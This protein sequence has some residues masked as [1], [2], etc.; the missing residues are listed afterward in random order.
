VVRARTF[1]FFIFD[2]IGHA[3]AV[4]TEDDSFG[5]VGNGQRVYADTSLVA[6]DKRFFATSSCSSPR[7]SYED[8]QD[9]L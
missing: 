8:D 6:M 2:I 7:Q 5:P 9:W 1:F 3:L 4:Q